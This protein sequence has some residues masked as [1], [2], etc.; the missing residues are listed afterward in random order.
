ML[1][2][3]DYQGGR[4]LKAQVSEDEAVLVFVLPPSLEELE[5]RLRQRATDAPEAIE[6]RLQGARRAR[7]STA[8]TTT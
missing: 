2:D 7:S 3:I 6:R 4:Q 8:F 1:F 5:R